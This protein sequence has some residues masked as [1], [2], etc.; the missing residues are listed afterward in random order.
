MFHWG[1]WCQT[2][3]WPT[4]KTYLYLCK[5][6]KKYEILQTNGNLRRRH[7]LFNC[8]QV[9]WIITTSSAIQVVMHKSLKM[10]WR[11]QKLNS[12]GTKISS[13]PSEFHLLVGSKNPHNSLSSCCCCCSYESVSS[14]TLM[15]A[16]VSPSPSVNSETI[17]VLSLGLGSVSSASSGV[18]CFGISTRW[19]NVSSHLQHHMCE[20]VHLA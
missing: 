20:F 13:S 4:K 17:M 15:P 19:S 3:F 6:Y 9:I 2:M 1:Q 8:R 12:G 11:N 16:S 5:T 7:F 18:L 14:N 10:T